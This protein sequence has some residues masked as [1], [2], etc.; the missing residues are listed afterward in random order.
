MPRPFTMHARQRLV[1]TST[2]PG[3]QNSAPWYCLPPDVAGVH[4]AG[5]ISC[6]PECALPVRIPAHGG[7]RPLR[8][9]TSLRAEGNRWGAAL[10]AAECG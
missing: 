7:A 10:H 5:R 6:H 2:P 8:R 4:S 3:G 1:E 9:N